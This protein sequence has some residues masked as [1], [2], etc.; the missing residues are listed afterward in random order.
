MDTMLA[1]HKQCINTCNLANQHFSLSSLSNRLLFSLAPVKHLVT[2]HPK[3]WSHIKAAAPLTWHEPFHCPRRKPIR[4]SR[5]GK[6]TPRDVST[7]LQGD[8][9]T[10]QTCPIWSKSPSCGATVDSAAHTLVDTQAR[11]TLP[12]EKELQKGMTGDKLHVKR[13][14]PSHRFSSTSACLWF[15]CSP[16]GLLRTR[17]LL[18]LFLLQHPSV[19]LFSPPCFSYISIASSGEHRLNLLMFHTE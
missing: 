12:W 1:K 4:T 13:P 6:L 10:F 7:I 11:L 15:L 3:R 17:G 5:E 19:C 16:W 2:A 9:C 18:L 8:A 14:N